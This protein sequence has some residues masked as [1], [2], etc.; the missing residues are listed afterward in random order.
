MKYLKR[1]MD[2]YQGNN[3]IEKATPKKAIPRIGYFLWNYPEKIIMV[4]L[5][6]LLGCLPVITIPASFAALD[7]YLMRLYRDGYGVSLTDFWTEWKQE[8]CRCIP[9]GMLIAA[10]LFYGYYLMSVSYNFGSGLE[11][12]MLFGIGLAVMLVSICTGQYTMIIVSMF[13]L[14]VKDS[15]KN[16]CMIMFL[17]WKSSFLLIGW[18]GFVMILFLACM[19]YSVLLLIFCMVSIQQLV[20]CAI[21]NPVLERRM[22]QPYRQ[23]MGQHMI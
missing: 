13:H 19:P 3:D 12:G 22:I 9:F 7:T 11:Q 2:W 17:E 8:A 5:L 20:V 15:L 16:A 21:M 6:F 1:F 10:C 18:I 23:L 14:S 4:N